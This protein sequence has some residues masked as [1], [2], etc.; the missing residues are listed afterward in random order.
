[1]SHVDFKGPENSRMGKL[2]QNQDWSET[3]LGPMKEWPQSLHTAL[4]ICLASK[5]PISIC[6]SDELIFF[7]NDAW[8]ELIG[9][10][11]TSLGEPVDKVFKNYRHVFDSRLKQ[12]LSTGEAVELKKKTFSLNGG[13]EY[14]FNL[15]AIP[16]PDDEG[17]V[18]G[19]CVMAIKAEDATQTAEEMRDEMLHFRD[20]TDALPTAVYTTD[21]EGKLT[22]FNPAAVEFSGRKPDLG[23]DQWYVT[24]KLYHP[25]GTPMPH[26]EC[27]MAV[28]LR[29]GRRLNGAE[30]IAERPDGERIWFKAYPSPL[31]NGNGDIVGGINMLIDV[32]KQKK[33]GF[34]QKFRI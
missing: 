27:P 31:R 25:D 32:T 26:D 9:N 1:M 6:W 14:H 7:C 33:T 21:A 5:S 12:I 20:M 30:A 16:V 2:I 13:R 3:P 17:S 4:N 24:W 28:S 23:T 10:E 22:H 19:V 34:L 18:G 8:T 11:P 29:E 15:S